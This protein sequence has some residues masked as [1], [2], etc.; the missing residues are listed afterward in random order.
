MDPTRKLAETVVRR[1]TA[2]SRKRRSK[3]HARSASTGSASSSPAPGSHSGS[4]ASPSPI[5]RRSAGHGIHRDRRRVQDQCARCGLCERHHAPCARLRQHLVA[6]EPSDLADAARD[7]GA[8]RAQRRFRPRRPSRARPRLR[9]AGPAAARLRAGGGRVGLHK[10][11]VSGTI[12]AV[13]GAGKL[14]GL[15]APS[16]C[17]AYGIAGSRCGSLSAN[18]GS[19]TKSSHSGHAAQN[20]RGGCAP[21]ASRLHGIR[22]RVR[23]RPVLRSLLRPRN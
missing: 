4:D 12:G 2:T 14:L 19:M 22:R 20:G 15:D 3:S 17:M 11:G 21:G 13:T 18:T 16:F 7:P 5:R 6:P 9:G 10:P 1:A 8:R 23:K